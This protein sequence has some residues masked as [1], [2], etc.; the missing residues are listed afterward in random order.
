MNS[1]EDFVPPIS[2]GAWKR[3]AAGLLE[4]E[5]LWHTCPHR[6]EGGL[7]TGKRYLSLTY[8]VFARELFSE[9][10][11]TDELLDDTLVKLAYDAVIDNGWVRWM[12]PSLARSQWR[13]ERLFKHW[14]PAG[15]LE[16][17]KS[18]LL[19][20]RIAEWRA[21]A[22]RRELSPEQTPRELLEEFRAREYPNLSHEGLADKMGL[23]RSRYFTLKAGKRV[24]PDAYIKV[25][26]FTKIPV[27]ALKPRP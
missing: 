22:M 25:S 19:A 7:L 9:M 6:D 21:K 20:G 17:A 12:V 3:I 14:A 11:C 13:S 5:A 8:D 10:D 16:R 1:Y 18:H 2:P 23:E 15:S 26:H 24:R 4:I 27:S